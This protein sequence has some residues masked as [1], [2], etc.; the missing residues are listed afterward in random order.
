[1]QGVAS[2]MHS[3]HSAALR[4]GMLSCL[5][6]D[7]LNIVSRDQRV[8]AHGSDRSAHL[9]VKAGVDSPLLDGLDGVLRARVQKHVVRKVDKSQRSLQH[10]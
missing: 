8:Q 6:S 4:R 5:D 3:V 7:H 9:V 2:A 1:M 10:A